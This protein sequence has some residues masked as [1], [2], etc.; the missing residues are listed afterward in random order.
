MY[1]VNLLIYLDCCTSCYWQDSKTSNTYWDNFGNQNTIFQFVIATG[2]VIRLFKMR[3][4][5]IL[6]DDI[7]EYWIP[8][9]S[10]C[11]RINHN[12][13]DYFGWNHTCPSSILYNSHTN[14]PSVCDHIIQDHKFWIYHR[15]FKI[16]LS[17][18]TV[19]SVQNVNILAD[20]KSEDKNTSKLKTEK[21]VNNLILDVNIKMKLPIANVTYLVGVSNV[22]VDR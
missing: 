17:N 21:I 5:I 16:K 20:I 19:N 1:V 2:G 13:M 15:G 3:R 8:D 11:S 12:E 10:F 6:L 22:E 18:K 4:F 9:D 7:D 14:N